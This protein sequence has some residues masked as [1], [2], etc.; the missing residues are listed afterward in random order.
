[1]RQITTADTP[2]RGLSTSC[3]NRHSPVCQRGIVTGQ[4]LRRVAQ[5][6]QVPTGVRSTSSEK[7]TSRVDQ[8]T[9]TNLLSPSRR[10][11]TRP[12]PAAQSPASWRC[13]PACT[14]NTISK[15]YRPNSENDG[16]GGKCWFPAFMCATSRS[17]R[18]QGRRL[19]QSLRPDIDRE[20][21]Q[22]S[23]LLNAGCTLQ[24]SRELITREMTGALRCAPG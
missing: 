13:R 4:K 3:P 2:L 19:R 6:L 15:V 22:S 12:P 23:T 7:A 14:A 1:V 16:V 8:L 9:K 24:Q 20:V 11:T 17:P 18:A 5:S 21:R 10:A